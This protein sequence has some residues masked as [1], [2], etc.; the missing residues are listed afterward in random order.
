MK[1]LFLALA[2]SGSLVACSSTFNTAPFDRNT[3]T[4]TKEPVEGIVYY[5]PHFVYVT[6]EYTAL[7]DK[8]GILI[9]TH[10][11][12]NCEKIIQKTEVVIEPNFNEPRLLMNK[13]SVFS[14]GKLAATFSNGM[15]T[16]INS[17]S[18]P[19]IPELLEQ[20]ISFGKESKFLPLTV[21]KPAGKYACNAAPVMTSRR[22]YNYNQ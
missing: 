11:S 16:S 18:K 14:E 5:E 19:Q 4:T 3:W 20:A 12:G 7:V 6:Y 22:P 1:K 10:E 8:D 15:L 9:G 13:P 2:L 21:K 17:D